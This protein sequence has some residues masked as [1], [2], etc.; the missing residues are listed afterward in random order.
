MPETQT[1]GSLDANA[2][3][4]QKS[5]RALVQRFREC[6]L[7]TPELDARIL[8]AAALGVERSTLIAAPDRR[9]SAA[10]RDRIVS[11]AARRMAR[12]PVSRILGHREFFG[13]LFELQPSTLDPRPDTEIIVE[14][15]LEFARQGPVPAGQ[16]PR[17][18][19]AGTGTGAIL[20]SIL[21]ELPSATGVG[22]DI[23]GGAL[24]VATRN[25]ERHRV[26][27]RAQFLR[28]D[29]FCNVADT[30]DLIVSNPPYIRSDA[31]AALEPEVA[32]HDP[33]AALDGGKDGLDAY[34]AILEDV[35]RILGPA[36]WLI[37]EIGEGQ[38][39]AVLDLCAEA[40]LQ[41]GRQKPYIKCDLAGRP[42]CVAAKARW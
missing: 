31:I 8:I 17:V 20:I 1:N 11:F 37:V 42:R 32:A 21:A 25:A 3:T 9:L 19:D 15:A 27:D 40:G 38:A 35:R 29:W 41:T 30:F 18:L 2:D 5:L 6:G 12:E 10:D 34:R 36:G 28:S 7:D 13:R 16:S 33:R 22:I 4:V 39:N 24:A 14:A 23:D 26:A